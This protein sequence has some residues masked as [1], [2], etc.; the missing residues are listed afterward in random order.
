MNSRRGIEPR[1]DFWVE[2]G[3]R[4]WQLFCLKCEYRRLQ[5]VHF[6]RVLPLK[7]EILLLR[8][9]NSQ[10]RDEVNRILN[11]GHGE[12]PSISVSS[13]V[14]QNDPDNPAVPRSGSS[15]GSG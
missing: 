14:C 9:Q 12:S 4:S 15:D 11:G 13:R 8:L 5:F 2:L 1:S 7:A 3:I 6:F 10:L